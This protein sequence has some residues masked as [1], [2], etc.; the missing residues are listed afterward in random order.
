MRR[1]AGGLVAL[2]V[3]F[4]LLWLVG[5]GLLNAFAAWQ[6][7]SLGSDY[8]GVE[9]ETDVVQVSLFQGKIEISGLSVANP[10]GFSQVPFAELG[11][12]LVRADLLSFLS[13]QGRIHEIRARPVLL[14]VE[15][16]DGRFNYQVIQE[17][18][19]DRQR[20]KTATL[21]DGGASS[22]RIDQVLLEQVTARVR[23]LATVK[24]VTLQI[25]TVKLQ[26]IN[27][28]DGQA[29]LLQVLEQLLE[30]A[31]PEGGAGFLA[32]TARGVLESLLKGGSDR[33]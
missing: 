24:P 31:T 10:P 9:V 15:R 5:S 2:V 25:G 4:L 22:I 20:L 13:D 8:L 27:T 14:E 30:E 33:K 26:D 23:L 28:S 19:E 7:S 6:I 11:Y 21:A 1:V 18:L 16:K 12:L 17:H 29:A 3:I 32:D